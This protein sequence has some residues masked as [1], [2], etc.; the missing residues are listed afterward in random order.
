MSHD[1]LQPWQPLFDNAAAG[2]Y[3]LPADLLADR[4]ALQRLDDELAQVHADHRDPTAA[5]LDVTSATIAAARSG[6]AWPKVTTVS[7]ARTHEMHRAIKEQVLSDARSALASELLSNIQTQA[8]NLIADYL[9]PKHDEAVK[10][11][12]EYAALLPADVS[13]E[14]LLRADE[15]M[16]TA[17][18]DLESVVSAYSRITTVAGQLG[19]TTPP[20]HDERGEFASMRNLAEVWPTYEAP[21][22]VNKTAPWPTDDQR[23]KLLWLVH[24]G[25][26]LWLPTVAERDAAWW[27]KYGERVEAHVNNRRQARA[28]R[29]VIA[30]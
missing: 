9:R 12:R 7:D 15:K 3:D 20:K 4:A 27:E 5:L 30:G 22:W 19:R 18:L 26:E 29:D 1:H 23:R 10:R 17:W 8:A 28:M 16:R 14:H 11:I 25:A 2:F 21:T 6:K 13:A 24:N